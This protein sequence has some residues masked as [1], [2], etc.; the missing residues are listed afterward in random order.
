MKNVKGCVVAF[1]LIMAFML[2]IKIVSG[3]MVFGQ[4]SQMSSVLGGVAGMMLLGLCGEVLGVL[5]IWLP[6]EVLF[7]VHDKVSSPLPPPTSKNRIV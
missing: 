6:A 4:F 3:L 7:S 2:L 5:V 1:R